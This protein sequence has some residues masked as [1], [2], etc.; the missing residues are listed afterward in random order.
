ML[1]VASGSVLGAYVA[2]CARLVFSGKLRD[3]IASEVILNCVPRPI[4]G[5]YDA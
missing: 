4:L 5:G 3:A 2:S 1:I